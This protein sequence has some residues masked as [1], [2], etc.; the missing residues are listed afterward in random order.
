MDLEKPY[1]VFGFPPDVGVA[2]RIAEVLAIIISIA[3]EADTRAGIGLVFDGY[4]NSIFVTPD[5]RPV[6]RL[7]WT[8]SVF[9]RNM[10]GLLGLF[11]VFILI[12]R[13][14]NVIELLLNFPAVLFVA[15]LDDSAYFIAEEGALGLFCNDM[16]ET[17]A[18]T[19][20]IIGRGTMPN[21]SIVR[22]R[23][24]GKSIF[25]RIGTFFLLFLV[26]IG[27]WVSFGI[28]K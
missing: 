11:V 24:Q 5:G 26:Y 8:L 3:L 10:T 27:G 1:N 25:L 19:Y 2:V 17:V 23:R 6:S 16:A 20:Y 4:N 15:L 21:T 9:V 7:N 18:K 12:M 22:E 14:D 13:S 28:N